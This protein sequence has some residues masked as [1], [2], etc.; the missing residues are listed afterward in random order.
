M[1]ISTPFAFVFRCVPRL[2]VVMIL[3]SLAG[4]PATSSDFADEDA[5]MSMK[6]EWQ[7][8]YRRL[9]IDVKLL[10]RNA[11]AARENYAR[12]KR[13][14][15]PRGGAREQFLVDEKEAIKELADVQLEIEAITEKGH[16]EGIL[17][18]WFAEVEDGPLEDPQPAAK[19][20][21]EEDREGRNPLY[22]DDE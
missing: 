12:A 18:G 13:R 10:Q 21:E 4:A 1:L 16:R 11:E 2:V 6:A 8:N 15:Y 17:P 19:A 3:L 14:N 7:S 5:T 9:L 22:F 20:E